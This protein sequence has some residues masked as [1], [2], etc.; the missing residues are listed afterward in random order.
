[1]V[2]M[3]VRERVR[4]P[5]CVCVCVCVC[6]RTR[7]SMLVPHCICALVSGFHFFVWTFSDLQVYLKLECREKVNFF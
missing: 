3:C 5:V 2:G 1:M 6:V 4:V 7:V